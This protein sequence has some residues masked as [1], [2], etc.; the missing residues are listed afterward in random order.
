M[1][2]VHVRCA[3][4]D[5]EWYEFEGVNDNG[6][7]NLWVTRWVQPRPTQPGKWEYAL[8][9]RKDKVWSPGDIQ[10][11][12]RLQTAPWLVSKYDASVYKRGE[13][14]PYRYAL[15]SEWLEGCGRIGSASGLTA[16]EAAEEQRRILQRFP[17]LMSLE[18]AVQQAH[19]DGY[20]AN[21]AESRR[22][23]VRAQLLKHGRTPRNGQELMLWHSDPKDPAAAGQDV[24][25]RWQFCG[26][27]RLEGFF[28]GL[29]SNSKKG[30]LETR[31]LVG[32]QQLRYYRIQTKRELH[33]SPPAG[34]PYNGRGVSAAKIIAVNYNVGMAPPMPGDLQPAFELAERRKV[35]VH[36]LHGGALLERFTESEKRK[37]KADDGSARGRFAKEATGAPRA[38]RVA[39]RKA[40]TQNAAAER[41]G[42]PPAAS[43]QQVERLAAAAWTAA[44]ASYKERQDEPPELLNAVGTRGDTNGN[45]HKAV[46]TTCIPDDASDPGMMVP[47]S[48]GTLVQGGARSRKR[49]LN[50]PIYVAAR[51]AAKWGLV[52]REDVRLVPGVQIPGVVAS[53]PNGT[54][55]EEEWAAHSHQVVAVFFPTIPSLATETCVNSPFFGADVTAW[56]L[57]CMN[58]PQCI[59]ARGHTAANP[60]GTPPVWKAHNFCNRKNGVN[61]QEE[62]VAKRMGVTKEGEV[63]GL[64]SIN[65]KF[66]GKGV[67]HLVSELRPA[68]EQWSK[69]VLEPYQQRLQIA[70]AQPYHKELEEWTERDVRWLEDEQQRI[71]QEMRRRLD[72][73]DE[74][75]EGLWEDPVGAPSADPLQPRPNPEAMPQPDPALDPGPEPVFDMMLKPGGDGGQALAMLAGISNSSN[76]TKDRWPELDFGK[77]YGDRSFVDIWRRMTDIRP[78]HLADADDGVQRPPAYVD[79]CA[80]EGMCSR[81]KNA[82]VLGV[83]FYYRPDFER[84]CAQSEELKTAAALQLQAKQQLHANVALREKVSAIRAACFER[85]Q[86][87]QMAAKQARDDAAL[88][89]AQRD[90]D[91]Q[92]RERV[93]AHDMKKIKAKHDE[94]LPTALYPQLAHRGGA[95]ALHFTDQVLWSDYAEG[96]CER[97]PAPHPSDA[98]AVGNG[99]DGFRFEE[100]NDFNRRYQ[101][102][103]QAKESGAPHVPYKPCRGEP[104]FSVLAALVGAD[105]E[106]QQMNGL[107]MPFGSSGSGFAQRLA[108]DRNG[109]RFGEKPPDQVGALGRDLG[110]AERL[111]GYDKANKSDYGKRVKDWDVAKSAAEQ[112]RSQG[113]AA[114]ALTAPSAFVSPQEKQKSAEKAAARRM[115]QRDA[116]L[117]QRKQ[118]MQDALAARK[119]AI[120]A[121]SRAAPPPAATDDGAAALAAALGEDDEDDEVPA[122]MA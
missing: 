83:A 10:P 100:E 14:A 114:T 79:A 76:Y 85:T 41:D 119:A 26:E 113:G 103:H 38:A 7:H 3:W 111:W 109:P 37:R 54:F 18:Q 95:C 71:T 96:H 107:L 97:P 58:R 39:R 43:E 31:P 47:D 4:Q 120:A 108:G 52:R 93:L 105:P 2:P 81:H 16:A 110:Q 22:L 87:R 64:D 30:R 104:A 80:N 101:E 117:A 78:P 73:A 29:Q 11:P 63:R 102:W 46:G 70:D 57:D 86:Q 67:A 6:E 75:E 89:V 61:G 12:A 55:T 5:G 20:D 17:R 19:T 53:G 59:A 66:A 68:Y 94:N 51:T 106:L 33:G 92:E 48:K 116:M 99:R 34:Q 27:E 77:L 72:G 65:N 45:D 82:F 35:S 1:Q 49:G 60:H 118:Q 23:H 9:T 32:D 115:A 69:D 15:N 112:R 42:R 90:A 62:A 40:A 36:T 8:C 122:D 44:E 121:E 88:A 74:E 98:D 91:E 24:Y 28:T 50:E 13:R 84:A 25:I 21:G 56:D